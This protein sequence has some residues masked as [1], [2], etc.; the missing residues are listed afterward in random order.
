MRKVLLV[1]LLGLAACAPATVQEQVKGYRN[2]A[3]RYTPGQL[4]ASLSAVEDHDYARSPNH[5]QP[6]Y[7]GG[8]D[9][10]RM[11]VISKMDYQVFN[12]P[13]EQLAKNYAEG[14]QKVR[15]SFALYDRYEDIPVDGPPPQP[16]ENRV[17][18]DRPYWTSF[19]GTDDKHQ[20]WE[21]ASEYCVDAPPIAASN[22]LVVVRT[23]Q[24]DRTNLYV[25]EIQGAPTASASAAPPVA[26]A[27]AAT[28]EASAKPNT[29]NIVESLEEAK[30]YLG[31]LTIVDCA[32]KKDELASGSFSVLAFS[33]PT[34]L[35]VMPNKK[36]RLGLS[37]KPERCLAIYNAHVAKEVSSDGAT[38]RTTSLDGKSRNVKL[39]AS[40]PII[41]AAN[42]KVYPV[43][44]M[45]NAR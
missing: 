10:S 23:F 14:V 5:D 12:T 13:P 29:K 6:V 25:F 4:D 26:A 16:S 41:E 11:C 8:Y 9:G 44:E 30:G 17:T 34:I 43:G 22:R 15:L 27:P 39:D 36:E 1:G 37:K 19:D 7:W 35:R 38:L 28:S 42:G 3:R 45:L 32:G 18:L 31:F 2:H 21:A 33:D 40:L 24:P 20:R